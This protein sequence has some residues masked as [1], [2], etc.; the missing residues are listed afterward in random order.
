M[1]V[2]KTP[3]RRPGKHKVAKTATLRPASVP[4]STEVP[5]IVG[6]GA[7]AGGQEAFTQLLRALPPDPGMAFVL[8][9]HLQPQRQ[10]ILAKLLSSAT[11]MPVIEAKESMRVR[12]NRVYVIAPNTDLI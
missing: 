11:A 10:S 5:T 8:V 6:V 12:P 7:S 2:I 4:E 1:V 3:S 9:Q